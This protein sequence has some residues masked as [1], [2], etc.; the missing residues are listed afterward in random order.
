MISADDHE[1]VALSDLPRGNHEAA[2]FY[3]VLTLA[4]GADRLA[5]SH[6][7]PAETAAEFRPPRKS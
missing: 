2:L 4:S 3:A 1:T 7:S 5:A 6:E